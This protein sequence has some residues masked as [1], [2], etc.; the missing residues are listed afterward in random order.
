MDYRNLTIQR[1]L[2]IVLAVALV[3]Y[4]VFHPQS[5]LDALSYLMK[6]FG[7]FIIGAV[8]AFVLNVP[9]RFF[10]RKFFAQFTSKKAKRRVR[11]VSILLSI[12]LVLLV[13][14]MVISMVV[15]QLV[16]S[17]TL[18]IS[19]V[20]QYLTYLSDFLTMFD[21]IDMVADMKD[22]IDAI[23]SGNIEKVLT[24][25]VMNL[26]AQSAFLTTAVN[27]T[28]DIVSSVFSKFFNF[29]IELVFAIY[30]LASKETLGIQARKICYAIFKERNASYLIHVAQVSFA[31]FYSFISGQ[32]TEA[33]ILGSLCAIGMAV[34]RLPYALMIGALTGFCALVPIFGA[35]I[36]G[37]VG[38]L[39][40]LTVDPMKAVIFIVFLVVLQQIEG[41]LI[42]PRVVGGSVG[43]P[44]MWTLFAI[45]IGGALFGL[46]GMMIFVPIMAIFYFLFAEIIHGRLKE[47][48]IEATDERILTG[49]QEDIRL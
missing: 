49:I 28:V 37:A 40:I 19:M 35:F 44:A 17:I 30:I 29:L 48:N 22:R 24:S 23:A 31:K 5:V 18:F 43:L 33:F 46:V 11:M 9:L 15:P 7:P 34:L 47:N 2:L 25:E 26:V 45:T 38:A 12:L 3:I 42:Y 16:K 27:S 14:S 21:S 36:G 4:G 10:E 39:L 32:L 41:N 20:P 6:L 1:L 8:M 13:I